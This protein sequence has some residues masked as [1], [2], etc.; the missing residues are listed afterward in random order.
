MSKHSGNG[1]CQGYTNRNPRGT[2]TAESIDAKILRVRRVIP[3]RKS[4]YSRGTVSNSTQE[5]IL[6]STISYLTI[7]ITQH[8]TVVLFKKNF[9]LL[10]TSLFRHVR[11]S[12]ALQVQTQT[13]TP[14]AKNTNCNTHAHGHTYV[15]LLYILYIKSICHKL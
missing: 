12:K 15:N 14:P 4:K 10:S 6:K 8:T 13:V 5:K 9:T 11:K 3:R 2:A 7:K 1:E